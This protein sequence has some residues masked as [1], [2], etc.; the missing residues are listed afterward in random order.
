MISRHAGSDGH[1]TLV[2]LADLS[3]QVLPLI[4]L[5]TVT[6]G[7][8]QSFAAAIPKVYYADKARFHGIRNKAARSVLFYTCLMTQF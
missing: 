2:R 4:G 8:K 3:M 1:L 6:L 5:W 7:S